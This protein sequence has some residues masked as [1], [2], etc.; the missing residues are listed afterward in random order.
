MKNNYSNIWRFISIQLYNINVT[1]LFI[2]LCLLEFIGPCFWLD[3]SK[4]FMFDIS[5]KL[6]N[7]K[8]HEH[9]YNRYLSSYVQNY[10][11]YKKTY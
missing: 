8:Y 3:I 2:K 1:N 4:K 5:V 6:K 10:K 7:F 11:I 9:R